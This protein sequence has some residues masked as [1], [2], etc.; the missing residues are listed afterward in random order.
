M[1]A[2]R[3]EGDCGKGDCRSRIAGRVTGDWTLG[4]GLVVIR[5]FVTG[6]VTGSTLVP[7]VGLDDWRVA[8]L[9]VIRVLVTGSVTGDILVSRVG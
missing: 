2:G 1:V 5:V 4:A 3:R 7:G 8:G 9:V 6:R